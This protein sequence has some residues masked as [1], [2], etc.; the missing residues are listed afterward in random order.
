MLSGE[1][2]RQR[3]TTHVHDNVLEAKTGQLIV[4]A[5][6]MITEKIKEKIQPPPGTSE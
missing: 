4:L 3:E 5:S 6:K 2:A 1:R